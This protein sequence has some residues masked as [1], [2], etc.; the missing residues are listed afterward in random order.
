MSGYVR[1][2][3]AV[4]YLYS[5]LGMYLIPDLGLSERSMKESEVEMGLCVNTPSLFPLCFLNR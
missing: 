2:L 3:A 4:T 1:V 5:E